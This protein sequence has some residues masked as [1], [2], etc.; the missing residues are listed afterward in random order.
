MTRPLLGGLVEGSRAVSTGKGSAPSSPS[1]F[2]DVEIDRA[3]EVEGGE[4]IEEMAVLA[5]LAYNEVT[6]LG[7]AHELESACWITRS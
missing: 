2:T 5:V 7:T 6:A 4:G 3:N 1:T